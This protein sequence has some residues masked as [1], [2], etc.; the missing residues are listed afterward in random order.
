MSKRTKLLCSSPKL[1]KALPCLPAILGSKNWRRLLQRKWAPKAFPSSRSAD[2]VYSF[3]ACPAGKPLAPQT[4]QGPSRSRAVP[5]VWS[6]DSDNQAHSS[7]HGDDVA[8]VA[9]T[10]HCD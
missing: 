2:R 5:R 8:V 3:Q 6:A 9:V 7:P 1:E 10:H 4:T